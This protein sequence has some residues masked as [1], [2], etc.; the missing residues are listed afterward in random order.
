MCEV[1]RTDYTIFTLLIKFSMCEVRR[2]DYTIFTLLIKFLILLLPVFKYLNGIDTHRY[3]A[4]VEPNTFIKSY[5][6]LY[7]KQFSE[8]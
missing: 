8:P 3:Y 7:T 2:T 5:I 6:E 4:L 1:R